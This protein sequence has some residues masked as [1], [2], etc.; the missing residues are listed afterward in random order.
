MDLVLAV[1]G[2]QIA[3]HGGAD[4]ISDR[5]AI[6]ISLSRPQNLALYESPDAAEL[7]AAYAYAFGL[8]K[9]HGFVDGN[10]RVAWIAA[11]VFLL[12]NGHSLRFNKIDATQ[13]MLS[14]AA[15]EIGESEFA[16]W[17]RQRLE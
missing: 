14:L 6:E 2:H 17:I 8:A 10:K 15:G 1:H 3:E 12:D 7:A 4:G 11:R 9:N 16:E 5:A 13:T